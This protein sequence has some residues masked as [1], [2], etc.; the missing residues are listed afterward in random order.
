MLLHLDHASMVHK[1]MCI[2]FIPAAL[3]CKFDYAKMMCKTISVLSPSSTE[4]AIPM[5]S[6][7]NAPISYV[8]KEYFS[9]P[10]KFLQN[11]LT[12]LCGKRILRCFMY[13]AIHECSMHCKA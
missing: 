1:T 4:N 9:D 13:H 2:W 12:T 8:S 7:K 6:K 3:S 11:T 5:H 10:K